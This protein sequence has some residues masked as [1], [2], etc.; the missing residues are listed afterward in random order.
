MKSKVRRVLTPRIMVR[1]TRC[2]KGFLRYQYG[3]R[4]RMRWKKLDNRPNPLMSC[5]YCFGRVE[6]I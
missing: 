2:K 3:F 4:G 5:T 1:C 6:I